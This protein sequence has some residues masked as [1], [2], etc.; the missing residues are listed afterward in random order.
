MSSSLS[1]LIVDDDPAAR[2][3]LSQY[4]DQHSAL[5]MHD[6]CGSAIEAVNILRDTHIDLLLLDIE[7]PEMSGLELAEFES[8]E[9]VGPPP[10]IVLITGSEEYAVD[11]FEL[12]VTDYL[13]K[14]VR[15]ARFLKAVSRVEEERPASSPS[16][17]PAPESV[18]GIA[19]QD[20]EPN[21]A[22]LKTGGRLVRVSFDDVQFVKAEGDYMLVV[23]S[24]QQHMVNS[25]MKNLQSKLPSNQFMR[26]HRSYLIRL[27]QLEEIND[28]TAVVGG[29][30]IPIGPSYRE[31]LA[32][33]IKTL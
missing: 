32:N 19:V 18:Q 29:K 26:I 23:T 1:C 7:L 16:D 24:S 12:N 11:A 6:T 2:E 30:N 3:V 28:S 13:V 14:P 17:R 10:A 27:D 9:T 15:Y 5:E 20:K 31:E 25:T 21:H 4:V 22:F 8:V 33:R